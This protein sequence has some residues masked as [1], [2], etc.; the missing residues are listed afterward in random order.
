MEKFQKVL[1]K[2]WRESCKEIEIDKSTKIITKLLIKDLPLKQ[3]LIR[4]IDPVHYCLE[5]I[6][7]G[8]PVNN[9][10]RFFSK[11]KCSKD[12]IKEILLW[13]K[14]GNVKYVRKN[15]EGNSLWCSILQGFEKS[16][17]LI[18][19]IG[20][21]ER[22]GGGI[23]VLLAKE[24]QHFNDRHILLSQALL[25]PFSAAYQNDRRL[26]E[27]SAMQEA[28]EADKRSLLNRLGRR[29]IGDTIVGE[30]TG[31]RSVME[32]VKL[33]AKSDTP[34][35][36]FGETGSGKELVARA[37]HYQS[38]RAHNPFIR[39]NCGAIPPELIDSEL[40]GHEKGAFTN[41]IKTRR[42]WFE[43]A[44]K[45]T[46]FLDEI[47]DLPPAAQVRMLRILQDGWLERVG[48]HE[49][50]HVDVRIVAATNKDLTEM[51]RQKI[52][53]EDLMYRIAIF[54]IMLPPLRDRHDDIP[55]LARYFAER[56]S[57]KLG[58]RL[59]LPTKE[60]LN[61]LRSYS[62]PGNI[63]ELAAVIERAAILGNGERLEI[64]KAFGVPIKSEPINAHANIQ[65]KNGAYTEERIATLDEVMK[66]HIQ[67]ALNMTQ[68]RIE[69]SH[70][71]AILLGMNPN[72]LRARMRKLNIKRN[73]F[74]H[75]TCI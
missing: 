4:R 56:A 61:L 48:G 20:S 53:R 7:I 21:V 59:V 32:R 13:H 40:F 10:E 69:G 47:G 45:G 57:I 43:R 63:R 29:A 70:G 67:Y 5:T 11:T 51:V 50:I 46:L 3:L 18:G 72:T 60:D 14:N 15:E 42:G 33:V 12:Q 25:D 34:T 52:F 27:I 55:E 24:R 28:A 30:Q 23:I 54:P 74:T 31:L 2:I 16:D 22:Y 6:T 35:L 19:P 41:A 62:W 64:A 38:G 71:C 37:I 17:M 68:G 26:E 49:Q 8:M 65:Q 39:V 44:D 73:E 58:T 66:N 36:I 9:E 1:L 75:K